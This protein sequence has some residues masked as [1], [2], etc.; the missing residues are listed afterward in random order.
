MVLG[1]MVIIL[2]TRKFLLPHTNGS[3]MPA[4]LSLHTHTLAEHYQLLTPGP[5]F[6]IILDTD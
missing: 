5:G 6:E 4:D 2:L 3:S 1:T